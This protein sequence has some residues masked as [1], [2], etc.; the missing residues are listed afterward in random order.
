MPKKGKNQI[1]YIENGSTVTQQ[2]QEKRNQ[3]SLYY[4]T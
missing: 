4:N 2:Q 1:D 3:I